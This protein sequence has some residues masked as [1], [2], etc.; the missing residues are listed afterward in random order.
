MTKIERKKS[1]LQLQ[2]EVLRCP[3]FMESLTHG[4]QRSYH[5]SVPL[6]NTVF[7]SRFKNSQ[8]AHVLLIICSNGN[9]CQR[10]KCGPFGSRL[11]NLKIEKKPLTVELLK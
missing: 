4:N 5:K 6:S 11:V 8:L 2:T 3:G 10:I 7:K 9:I 1:L